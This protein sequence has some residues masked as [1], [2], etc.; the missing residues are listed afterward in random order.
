MYGFIRLKQEESMYLLQFSG[1]DDIISRKPGF[2]GSNGWEAVVILLCSIMVF[3]CGEDSSGPSGGAAM[4]E[5]NVMKVADGF[6]SPVQV[7][8]AGDGSGRLFV[9]EQPGVIKIMKNDGTVLAEPFLNISGWV[10][11]GGERGLL[12]V[13]FPPDFSTEGYLYVN[14]TRAEDGAT[15]VARYRVDTEDSNKVAGMSEEEILVVGQPYSNHN[16][17]MMAFGPDG[18]LYVALGDGGGGGDPDGNGQDRTTLLGSL[19]RLEVEGGVDFYRIP[20]DNPFAGSQ[21]YRPEIWAYGLRNPWRFSFDRSTGDLYIADVGQNLWEE[22][23]YQPS[24]SPGGENYGW[25]IMEGSHCYNAVSCDSAGLV[26]PVFE[27]GHDQGCSVTGGYV[28]RGAMQPEMF[29]VYFFADYCEGTIWGMVKNGG[30]WKA[31]ALVD[32]NLSIVSFGEGE[33]G[34]IYV[35]DKNGG[36][37]RIIEGMDL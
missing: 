7:T 32:T 15:L 28:Y 16:G 12:S 11:Y 6:D 26:L 27:Y 17:G 20:P 34:E 9:V 21:D 25:N 35:V 29:G 30:D 23:D 18:Y 19:L 3:G 1:K 37:Y 24:G 36:V 33:S 14:Y 4:P 22:I 10:S 2:I 8:S 31:E 13:A 5:I